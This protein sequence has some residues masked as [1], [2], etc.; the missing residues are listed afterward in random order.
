MDSNLC[1]PSCVQVLVQSRNSISRKVMTKKS[2]RK[3][4][5]V[6]VAGGSRFPL[7]LQMLGG[8]VLALAVS[9]AL[10]G[11]TR[12]TKSIESILT[13]ATD[14]GRLA[15]VIG[16]LFGGFVVYALI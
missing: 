1:N 2:C 6:L 14:Y 12:F 5:L 8:L 10:M 7:T 3:T 4:L 9:I 15:G 13:L 16:M 11:R